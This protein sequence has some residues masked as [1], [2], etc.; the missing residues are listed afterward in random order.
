[1]RRYIYILLIILFAACNKHKAPVITPWGTVI[2]DSDEKSSSSNSTFTLDDIQQGGELI[3]LTL[4][5]PD[6]YYDYHGYGMGLNY[7][8]LERFAQHI[9]VSLRVEV[10]KDTAELFN[11][12][13]NGDADI[14]AI[15]VNRIPRGFV[16]CGISTIKG[17]AGWILP[18]DSRQ[19]SSAL[20][21]WFKPEMIAKVKKDEAFLLSSRSIRRH[22]YSPMLN[23]ATGT[24][25]RFDNWFRMY[26]SAAGIDWRLMAAQCYQESTFD[27]KARSWAGACGLMQI[28]PSTADHLGL[29]RSDMYDPER[30]IAAAARYMQ[31]LMAHFSDIG[32]PLERSLFALASYN[33]G[34]RHVRDAMTLARKKGN[35]PYKWDDVSSYIVKLQ[36]PQFFNDPSVRYGYMRGSETVDYVNRIRERWRQYR[37]SAIGGS[38]N[39]NP[40]RAKR[41]NKYII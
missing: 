18:R 12:L 30:N 39:A 24:I 32:N 13:S 41:K 15:P 11:R 20:R 21:S 1:M 35:N 26:A 6:T 37:G 31:E 5:G 27:P 9:G 16:S 33:G 28:M 14:I 8:L 36:Q 4:S 3:M 34:S 10:C 19:L 25:S 7:L 22:V 29:A 38:F 40:S 23:R 17:C 2:S